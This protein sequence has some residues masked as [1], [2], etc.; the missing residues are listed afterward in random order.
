MKKKPPQVREKYV[1]NFNFNMLD[2]FLL[3]VKHFFTLLKCANLPFL[4]FVVNCP[5]NVGLYML[6][7]SW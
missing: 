6:V 3:Y 1:F 2:S 5:F 4:D 7:S